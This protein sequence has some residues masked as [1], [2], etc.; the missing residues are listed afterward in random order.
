MS[1]DLSRVIRSTYDDIDDSETGR[2][3]VA[4]AER[5]FGALQGH[6]DTARVTAVWSA[7]RALIVP[8][9]A[10]ESIEPCVRGIQALRAA[11]APNAPRQR[12][13]LPEP[14]DALFRPDLPGEPKDAR[15][16]AVRAC[17][18]NALAF[19][20]NPT[21]ARFVQVVEALVAAQGDEFAKPPQEKQRWIGW[22]DD[23]VSRS[24]RYGLGTILELT[25]R[26]VRGTLRVFRPGFGWEGTA[27]D[28]HRLHV[29]TVDRPTRHLLQNVMTIEPVE[30]RARALAVTVL[31]EPDY[32]RDPLR[33]EY[34]VE[35]AI[36]R[37][38]LG[39]MYDGRYDLIEYKC[40]ATGEQW[41]APA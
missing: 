24:Y 22:L 5:L 7:A 1:P 30:L 39:G 34:L 18:G 12:S 41:Q 36:L 37:R 26:T 16:I 20:I 15:C 28:S 4:I 19:C 9:V 27:D 21:A 11:T 10:A 23:V 33:I 35:D 17:L 13:G 25:E 31:P 29:W 32:I 14:I 8:Q 38:F 40:L 2:P 3:T 6:G